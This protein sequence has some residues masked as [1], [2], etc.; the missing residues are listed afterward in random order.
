MRTHKGHR[1]TKFGVQRTN[2]SQAGRW[3]FLE[4][5]IFAFLSLW[6][7]T[8]STRSSWAQTWAPAKTEWWRSLW[9]TPHCAHHRNTQWQYMNIWNKKV[10]AVC[11]HLHVLVSVTAGTAV[12]YKQNKPVCVK[13]WEH[14]IVSSHAV[15]SSRS[16]TRLLTWSMKALIPPS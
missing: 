2:H 16:R 10:Y 4:A 14:K 9:P 11:K 7:N 6:S 13:M 1:N 3:L 5:A 8:A 12:R 15:E